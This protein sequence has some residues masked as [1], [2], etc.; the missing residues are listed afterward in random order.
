[1]FVYMSSQSIY[2]T[3]GDSLW[4]IRNLC[5]DKINNVIMTSIAQE[6]LRG[7]VTVFIR[8]VFFQVRNSIAYYETTSNQKELLLKELIK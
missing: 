1:M 4:E 7:Q 6:Y 2:Y 8:E 5:K 3:I